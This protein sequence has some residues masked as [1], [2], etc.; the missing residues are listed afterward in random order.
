MPFFLNGCI[1]ENEMLANLLWFLSGAVMYKFGSYIFKLGTTINLFTQALIGSLLMVK[2]IDDQ[3]LLS[4]D[5]RMD[6]LKKEGITPEEI[7]DITDLNMQT[8][9]LWRAMMIGTIISC[10]PRSIQTTLKFN[11]WKSA[12]RVLK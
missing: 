8:H 12:M 5:R 4:L 1:M 6:I 10:C 2:K 9:E 7:K 3:M 11:D